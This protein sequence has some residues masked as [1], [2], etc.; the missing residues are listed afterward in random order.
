MKQMLEPLAHEERQQQ[1]RQQQRADTRRSPHL[2]LSYSAFLLDPSAFFGQPWAFWLLLLL[3]VL[4]VLTWW[5][6]RWKRRQLLRFGER[7][8]LYLAQTIRPRRLR[9]GVLGLGL[10]LLIAGIAGP[11][12]GRD[13]H[14]EIRSGRDIVVVLDIS[15]SML[16]EQPSRLERAQ[17]V[18]LHLCEMMEQRGGHR[19]GLVVFASQARIV[20]P[21]T[22]DYDHFR[23]VLKEQDPLHLPP[24][25]QPQASRSPSGTRIG[26]GLAKAMELHDP[27]LAGSQDI[28][29]LSD[30]D[31]PVA[32]GE[33]LDG[34]TAARQRGI[35]V[36][37]VGIGDPDQEQHIPI[38]RG[39]LQYGDHEVQTKLHEE[40]LRDIARRTQGVYI[41]AQTR[42]LPLGTLYREILQGRHQQRPA[43]NADVPVYKQRYLWF[44]LPALVLLT[45]ALLLPDGQR[46]P[47]AGKERS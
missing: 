43:D 16:A 2:A 3:P 10:L 20:C 1:Q 26:Q 12:W 45:T 41:P 21:L 23:Q 37:V 22:H 35:P 34:T 15:R 29:L 44:L 27:H 36:D 9:R 18:L 17:R 30:G 4:A 39:F 47:S 11:Q 5:A 28:L 33:W 8:T 13:W 46:G 6:E 42:A 14:H 31:D 19:L 38:G 24:E 25:L 32:D 40:I 7:Q